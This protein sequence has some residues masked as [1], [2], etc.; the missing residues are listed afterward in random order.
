VEVG[1]QNDGYATTGLMKQV[2]EIPVMILQGKFDQMMKG[3][4]G[5]GKKI[6]INKEKGLIIFDFTVRSAP[7]MRETSRAATLA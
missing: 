2:L 3:D 1:T 6:D 4:F 7:R 5:S